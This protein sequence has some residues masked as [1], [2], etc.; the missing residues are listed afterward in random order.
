[1][2]ARKTGEFIAVDENGKR[3][4]IIKYTD[5]ENADVFQIGSQQVQGNDE[6]HLTT[7]EPVNKIS[8]TEFVTVVSEIKLKAE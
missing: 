5:F 1:M 4:K 3:Y 8:E 7:G 6:F 2:V